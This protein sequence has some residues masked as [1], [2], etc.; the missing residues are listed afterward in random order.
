MADLRNRENVLV[1]II[2]TEVDGA[3][4][5]GDPVTEADTIPTSVTEALPTSMAL[6]PAG[7]TGEEGLSFAVENEVENINDMAGDVV[8]AIQS[9]STDTLSLEFM[10]AAN[11]DVLRAVK[12]EGDVTVETDGTIIVRNTAKETPYKSFVFDFLYQGRQVRIIVPNGRVTETGELVY[13]RSD[14]VRYPVTITC[15]P[16]NS[17]TRV[18]TLIGPK[19]D[20]SEG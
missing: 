7:F 1:G 10:E 2:N 8:V 17:G 6:K 18:Y 20:P 19:S 14:V 13:N 5:I 9:S 12:G 4:R 3:N 16:D 15:F 11:A